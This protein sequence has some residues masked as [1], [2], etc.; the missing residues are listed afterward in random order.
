MSELDRQGQLIHKIGDEAN[1]AEAETK[2]A[3]A[4]IMR[5]L[6]NE[7]KYKLIFIGLMVLGFLFDIVSIY[8]VATKGN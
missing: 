7:A 2:K 8:F 5:M 6:W 4:S 3:S 1:D